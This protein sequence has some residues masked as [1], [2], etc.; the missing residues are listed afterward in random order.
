METSKRDEQNDKIE[1]S[2]V[3]LNIAGRTGP[4]KAS[5]PVR[6]DVNRVKT[7]STQPSSLQTQVKGRPRR[8]TSLDPAETGQT[9]P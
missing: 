6:A 9:D 1:A 4:G 5:S 2:V 7:P 8:N 3:V